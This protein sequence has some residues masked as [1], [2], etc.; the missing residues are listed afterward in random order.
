L[1]HAL[2]RTVNL[3]DK[4]SFLAR[5]S[6]GQPRYLLLAMAV[7]FVA[8]LIP[9]GARMAID[10]SGNRAE[11]WLPIHYAESQDLA[12]FRENFLGEQFVLVSWD[13]C[14]LGSSE[15]LE[16]LAKKLGDKATILDEN[17][18]KAP[19]SRW[20]C[21]VI[22][23]PSAI[24]QLTGPPVG[25]SQE[26]AIAR[27]E[28]VLVGPAPRNA[29]GSLLGADARSTCLAV[30]LTP[31][32]TNDNRTM[33]AA[34][35]RIVEIAATQCDVNPATI[36]MGGPPVDNVAIDLESQRMLVRM[37]MAAGLAALALC[38][39]RLRSAK[40]AATVM[41]VGALAAGLSLAIV[42]YCGA[43]EVLG[44]GQP[45]PRMGT[46]DAVLT[47]LPAVAYVLGLSIA[48]QG[49]AYY[50]YCRNKHGLNGAVERALSVSWF[51]TAVSA[52]AMAVGLA[53]LCINDILPIKRFGV[54]G[55]IAVLLTALTAFGVLA[56]LLHRFPLDGKSMDSGKGR[57]SR[58]GAMVRGTF[59]LATSH[60][61]AA[62]TLCLAAVGVLGAGL[63][64]LNASVQLLNLIDPDAD[65]VRDY[66]WLE[67]RIGNLAPVEIV[68]TIP[69][70]R[71]RSADQVADDDGQQYRMTLLERVELVRQIHQRIEAIP[72]VGAALSAATFAPPSPAVGRGSGE[73]TA[74]YVVNKNLEQNRALLVGGDYLSLEQQPGTPERTGRELW[75]LSARV[76]ALP[77]QAEPNP[78]HARSIRLIRD[79]VDPVLL[80][81]QQRDC[82]VR[83]LHEKAKS[84]S[85]SRVCVLFRAPG[86][87]AAPSADAQEAILAR[88][89]QQSGLAARGAT[90]FN[91]AVYD[92]PR[93]QNADAD[94]SFRRAAIAALAEQDA[95]VLLSAASDPTAHQ[96]VRAGVVVTDA[97]SLPSVE[98]SI[99]AAPA[100]DGGPRPIRAVFTGMLPLVQRTQQEL[101]ASMHRSAIWAAALVLATVMVL[102]RNVAG[103]VAVTAAA[104]VPIVA[105]LGALGWMGVRIDVGMMMAA[106]VAF[107]V[108]LIGAMHLLAWFRRELIAGLD[109][110]QALATA[111]ELL[112]EPMLNTTLIAGLGM[113]VLTTSSLTPM[114]HF[115]YL[116]L[117]ALGLALVGDLI[118]LPAILA[119]PF[120]R[121]LLTAGQ[122]EA[123]SR[124]RAER[125][126]RSVGAPPP[127]FAP[128]AAEPQVRPIAMQSSHSTPPPPQQRN[129]AAFAAEGRQDIAHGPHASLHARL[130]ELR[131][132]AGGESDR[133]PQGAP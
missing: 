43:F 26:D 7:A 39:W 133:G 93:R 97:T 34:V 66:A 32:A 121:L 27:L 131:R 41:A 51:P 115:G 19:A 70:E 107:G 99:S 10:S 3:M 88:L 55:A 47:A 29:Q 71:R 94:Q 6:L 36:H 68:L 74:S 104:A 113:A 18:A 106:G 108:A 120:S 132:A 90:Y 65:L 59:N 48:L 15:K 85:G 127:H 49:V 117:A 111:F 12:W 92:H 118:V 60:Y 123:A 40:V 110:R 16:L 24:G 116:M 105:T 58:L 42:F 125:A 8:A 33:R 63:L 98:E 75:R 78:D 2:Q 91:L 69:P 89:L 109:R 21:R 95:V 23:G 102:L 67:Q 77:S 64:H 13:G 100:D 38:A 82:V 37:A 44:L 112:A 84:L 128:P 80:A 25:L 31:A 61:A 57:R 122:A 22:T 28:G 103:A 72:T 1:F 114:Q 50:R 5:K 124:I 52:V 45:Q 86:Q 62:L 81:Y 30:N 87:V 46:L 14:T 79:A 35:E 96:L 73:R 53:V 83:A 20:Y 56:V 130:L 17:G 119:S 129:R 101:A 76:A 9:Y 126:G 4:P 54:L 11:D